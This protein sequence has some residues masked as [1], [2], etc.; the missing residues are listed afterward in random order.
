M[1]TEVAVVAPALDPAEEARLSYRVAAVFDAS[2]RRFSR[3]R[4]DSELSRLNRS[5][6]PFVASPSLFAALRRAR[7]WV[8]LTDGL[9]DPTVGAALVAA[10]YDR[11]FA[12]AVLDRDAPVSPTPPP[13]CFLD[14]RLD[15]ATRTVVRPAGVQIDLGGCIKGFTAD[16]AA[17]LLPEDAA[18]DAGGD[19]VL[20]GPG[21]LGE[22]WM[23]D[24]E[25]PLDA[26]RT[27]VTLRVCDRAVATSADNR[28]RW[29]VGN[30]HCHHLIDPRTRQ[31]ATTDLAQATVIA[32]GA[33]R[34]DVLAKV[35]FL[36]GRRAAR[37]RIEKMSGVGAVL[38]G[39]DGKAELVGE[40]EV[41]DA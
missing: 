24:V 8:N 11:S 35:A 20:R 34:A 22:G 14:V 10:G 33:E 30:R 38:V 26:G 7:E 17:S 27:I 1:N 31:P 9:F 41:W 21:P 2:E 16:R 36:E 6:R 23:V 25:H 37:A 19:A 12:P 28:R 13:A 29:R 39:R 18:V 3:F 32:E 4:P 5:E 40:V 15:E